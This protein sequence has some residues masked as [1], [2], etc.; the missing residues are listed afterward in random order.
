MATRRPWP[1]R[2]AANVGFARRVRRLL[3]QWKSR[4]CPPLT[5]PR[6]HRYR[7]VTAPNQTVADVAMSGGVG[8]ASSLT[9]RL[10]SLEQAE[11]G[12][13]VEEAAS[14]IPPRLTLTRHL[15]RCPRR[16]AR[17]SATPE[18]RLT[19]AAT[20]RARNTPV[21]DLDQRLGHREHHAGRRDATHTPPSE[22]AMPPNIT[23]PTCVESSL[24]LT[25]TVCA[26]TVSICSPG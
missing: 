18:S 17:R 21:A 5:D 26:W 16:V 6:R 7:W 12:I 15:A 9:S 2:V 11:L 24:L 8:E 3:R 10:R 13:S 14:P 1:I 19:S 4:N 25:A 23:Q 20:G 22:N